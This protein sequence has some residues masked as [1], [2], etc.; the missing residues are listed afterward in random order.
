MRVHHYFV[1]AL[2]LAGCDRES[3]QEPPPPSVT[4]SAAEAIPPPLEQAQAPV[5]DEEAEPSPDR[6][7]ML[8]PSE[9][10]AEAPADPD[11]A[12]LSAV[13][14]AQ[15][16]EVKLEAYSEVAYADAQ[17]RYV[18][19]VL[20]R[21]MAYLALQVMTPEGA[22][23]RG[24]RPSF[25]VQGTSRVSPIDSR[26]TTDD[27]GSVSF[28]IVGGKMGADRVRVSV[29]DTT[30]D[31]VVNV[32]SLK[33]AGV[34]PL[35]DIEGALR[36]DTLMQARLR[37]ENDKPRADIP[38]EIAARNGQVVKL[39]GFMMPLEADETQK[40]F[41]LTANPPSCFFHVPGGPAGAVEVLAPKGVKASWD[42]IILEGRFSTS[43]SD[44]VGVIYR[45]TDARV[46]DG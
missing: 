3:A 38:A 42:P 16:K 13:E 46:I 30:L 11:D 36:W 5:D 33:A 26:D 29:K 20:E 39:V 44:E 8:S 40:R 21:D 23:V 45:M 28:G 32:I 18:V 31:V 7:G 19:D 43:P 27:T 2:V 14:V 34:E 12:E 24:A 9:M 6:P 15:A 4:P 1:L 17:N 35:K 41:L 25:E 37:F 22:P 10:Q